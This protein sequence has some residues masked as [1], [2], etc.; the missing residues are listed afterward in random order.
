VNLLRRR[1]SLW[2]L[3][4]SKV[5]HLR[6]QSNLQKFKVNLPK[7]WKLLDRVCLRPQGKQ[8]KFNLLRPRSKEQKFNL[9]WPLQQFPD[10]PNLR[11]VMLS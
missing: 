4:M 5:N 9:L 10:L 1:S 3:Q 2:F 11:L 7:L 6:R 8:Q